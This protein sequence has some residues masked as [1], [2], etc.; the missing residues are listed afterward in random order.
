MAVQFIRAA[1]VGVDGFVLSVGE[2]P[3]PRTVVFDLPKPGDAKVLVF[4]HSHGQIA[5]RGPG[6]NAV[7]RSR[8]DGEV[9]IIDKA[10]PRRL[11]RS[12]LGLG[13]PGVL[14]EM[15]E[16]LLLELP[17]RSEVVKHGRAEVLDATF[18]AADIG[19]AGASAYDR[20]IGKRLVD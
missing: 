2:L 7:E 9:A 5:L 3:V 18:L 8:G 13:L 20:E 14:R 11:D 19:H 16:K 12:P 4:N 17:R 10:R 6:A 15:D 1:D